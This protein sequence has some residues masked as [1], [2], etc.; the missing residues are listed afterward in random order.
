VGE[1][2]RIGLVGAGA[3]S[4][5]YLDRLTELEGL[6]LVAVADLAPQRAGAV[7]ER[8][9]TARALDIDDL[10]AAA[11]VDLVLNLT[12]PQAHAEVALRAIAA[13]KSVYGE[14]PLAGTAADAAIVLTAADRAGLALGCAPDTV[15]GTGIQTARKALDDGE[16]G[17]PIAA[18]ATMVTPGHEA[19]HPNPDFYYQPGGGPLL[20]MGPYYLT[21]LVTMLGPVVRVTGA[22]S[23]ARSERVIGSGPRR[24]EV[25]PVDVDTHVTGVLE[26]RGGVLS[27]IVMSFDAVGSKASRIEVHGARGTLVVP[28]PNTFDGDVLVCR[29][30]GT[31]WESLPVSAGYRNTGRGCGLADLATATPQRPPRASGLLAYHVLDVMERLLES[32][33]GG[34]RLPVTSYVERPAPV[35]LQDLARRV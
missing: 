26:H 21:A 16:I 32:A 5:A 18:T 29:L 31:E 27:T 22:A 25:I 2:L 3:I 15:L 35:P 33:H 10:L 17:T 28:D 12:V 14:K 9:P 13:G 19:W 6:E 11:D 23:R 8:V 30:G 20:D 24:G 7:L 34:M 4:G 1:P